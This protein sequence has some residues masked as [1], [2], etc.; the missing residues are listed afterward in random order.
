MNTFVATN[1]KSLNPRDHY[2]S[3]EAIDKAF[4]LV[5]KLDFIFQN[6]KF[7]TEK[8]WSA[9]KTLE[10][11]KLYREWLVLHKVYGSQFPFTP[12]EMVDEYWHAHIL[13]TQKYMDDCDRVFG[14]YLHHYPYFGLTE[15]EAQEDMEQGFLLTNHFYQL[16]FRHK[17][18]G[19]FNR[20]KS[21]SCR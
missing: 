2:A 4:E 15:E 7:M 19:A 18:M 9:E 6:H 11:E 8:G 5:K 1:I 21:T 20:C 17:L 14:S 12:N 3:Q 16:H 10:T 13:D